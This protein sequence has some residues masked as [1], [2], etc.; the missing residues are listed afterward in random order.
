MPH[1]KD[2]EYKKPHRGVTVEADSEE[3]SQTTEP[4]TPLEP[5]DELTP[6]TE[7]KVDGDDNKV[8]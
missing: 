2:E 7:P 1:P 6:S 3:E 5:S 4:T 8:E